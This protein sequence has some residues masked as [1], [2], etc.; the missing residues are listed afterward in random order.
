MSL[1]PKRISDLG[2]AP[3]PRVLEGPGRLSASALW[4]LEQTFYRR[5]GNDAWAKDIVPHYITCNPSI[6]DAYARTIAAFL[7]DCLSGGRL[8]LGEPVY[9]VE[10]GAGSGRFAY[11][12]RRRLSEVLSS[13]RFAGVVLTSVVTDFE[14]SKL[15]RL[16]DHPALKDDL[17]SGKLD[18]AAVDLCNPGEL[19]LWQSG[20]VL[21]R[22][23]NPLVLV[24]NY[25][26]DSLPCEAFAVR[27]GRLHEGLVS[28]SSDRADVV[29]G[30]PDDLDSLQITW[31]FEEADPIAIDDPDLRAV[32]VA[33]EAEL[34][35]TVFL[36]PTGAQRCLNQ[37]RSIAGSHPLL[38]LV[39]DKGHARTQDLL[40][41]GAPAFVTHNGCFSLMVNF[42][43]LAR[44]AERT[45]GR[46]YLPKHRP[47]SL[48]VGAFCYAAG[49]AVPELQRTY[50]DE[51]ESGG[52]DD[53]FA[54]RSALQ[55]GQGAQDLDQFLSYLR[56][57]N[58]DSTLLVE[59]FS[60]LLELAATASQDRRSDL[61]AGLDEIWDRYFPIGEAADVAVCIGLVMSAIHYYREALVYFERSIELHGPSPRT[62]FAAGIAH[63][64][65]R[66][67]EAA[68][69][70]ARDAL[71][72]DPGFSGAR[73]LL[74]SV[75][76]EQ[77][78]PT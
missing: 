41:A 17:E 20:A 26:F 66:D 59:W 9:V 53:L 75:E 57:S 74:V 15:R 38:A 1:E 34:D 67:L 13:S 37:F 5:H 2:V 3:P 18:L 69:K 55:P 65:L 47:A 12:L 52:P 10:V 14:E 63:Y 19:H 51:V 6:A 25:V 27:G 68:A 78:S 50:A 42:D 21:E 32:A 36:L 49:M 70:S 73:S 44:A 4:T 61:A 11:H 24:A 46:A 23:N 54:L 28:I 56:I 31:D 29:M 8:K 64:G 76:A 22:C 33:Y 71:A 43:A 39:A 72:L 58:W 48:V 30:D 77:G 45:G 7:G 35:D 16:Q 40:G 62:H 60:P